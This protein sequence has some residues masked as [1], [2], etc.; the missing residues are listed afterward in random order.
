MA[1]SGPLPAA[2]PSRG[3]PGPLENKKGASA[4]AVVDVWPCVPQGP[5]LRPEAGRGRP[6]SQAASSPNPMDLSHFRHGPVQPSTIPK[7]CAPKFRRRYVHGIF[8]SRSALA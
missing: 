3:R 2:P 5:G 1:D 7:P 4:A 6:A 8:L